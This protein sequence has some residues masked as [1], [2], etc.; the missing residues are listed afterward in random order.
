MI[1]YRLTSSHWDNDSS[2][3]PHQ[4][5]GFRLRQLGYRTP[6]RDVD[7]TLEW[8][9]LLGDD[10]GVALGVCARHDADN[11]RLQLPSHRRPRLR[12]KRHACRQR[13]AARLLDPRAAF[14]AGGRLLSRLEPARPLPAVDDFADTEVMELGLDGLITGAD[15][16]YDRLP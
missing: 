14:R 5:G 7:G 6:I 11:R 2:H 15:A 13:G 8:V 9:R 10:T 3:W 12:A 1:A 4:S 16:H